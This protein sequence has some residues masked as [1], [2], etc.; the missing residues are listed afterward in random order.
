[1]YLPNLGDTLWSSCEP[2]H[3]HTS[4]SAESRP[5]DGS[6]TVTPDWKFELQRG[7]L[8]YKVKLGHT[9][10]TYKKTYT[11]P[12][13]QLTVVASNQHVGHKTIVRFTLYDKHT[14]IVKYILFHEKGSGHATQKK[15]T[16][17]ARFWWSDHCSE[18]NL[19]KLKIILQIFGH[20]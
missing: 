13:I 10:D 1:M 19:A 3:R 18:D 16:L 17:M 5:S 11:L 8:V 7:R 9:W 4:R 2:K 15:H 20:F 12:Q 6:L 14:K